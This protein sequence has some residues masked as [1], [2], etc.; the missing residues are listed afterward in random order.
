VDVPGSKDGSGRFIERRGISPVRRL[1][2]IGRDWLLH[3]QPDGLALIQPRSTRSSF[4]CAL[5]ANGTS[6]RRDFWTAVRCTARCNDG[7]G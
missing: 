4:E 5:V 3:R 2:L 6:C 7:R 1:F